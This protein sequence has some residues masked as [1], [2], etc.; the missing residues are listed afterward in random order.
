[1]SAPV[2][3][4][5]PRPEDGKDEIEKLAITRALE[6]MGIAPGAPLTALP[7]DR[8]FV[9]SCTNGRLEDLRDAASVIKGHK[10]SPRVHMMVVPGSRVGEGAGRA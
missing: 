5:V 3:G 9:G 10:V 1:M 7:I 2:T 4:C 8:V 6:Y